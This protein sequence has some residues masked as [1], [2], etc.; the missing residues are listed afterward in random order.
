MDK[1]LNILIAKLSKIL[2]NKLYD[3]IYNIIIRTI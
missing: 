1:L 2:L 3:S